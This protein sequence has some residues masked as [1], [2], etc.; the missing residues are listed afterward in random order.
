MNTIQE[1]L[2]FDDVLIE[3]RYSNIDSR[4]NIKIKS[5]LTKNISLYLPLISSPMDTITESEMAIN[6][7]TNGG[8][9]IIH[10]YN[11][12][13]QQVNMVKNVKRHLSFIIEKPYTVY[14]NETIETLL[15]K[16]K[17][18]KV[19][20]Y[21]VT[22]IDEILVGI[23]TK[24]DLNVHLVSGN[25]NNIHVS[26]IMTKDL[27]TANVDITREEA[28]KIMNL[29]K[30]EKLPVVNDDN[31]IGLISYKSLMAYELNKDKYSLDSKGQLLVGAS[32]GI[33]DDYFERAS[34]LVEAGCNILCVDVANGYNERVKN[35]IKELKQLNVDIMA[36]NVCNSEGFEFLC[37][38]GADCI[39]VGIG[40]GSICSTRLVTGVGSGQFS[41]LMKCRQIA[42]LYKVGMISDGGHLGKDGNISKAFIVGSDA[43]MLGKTLAATD[44]TPGNIIYRN[45][46]RVKCYRGMASAM[47]MVSKAEM[48][49][50]EYNSSQNP[51]G[52]DIE[53][54][55]KGPVSDIL[56]R[57]ESS[58][59]ST[60]S[61]V[62]CLNTEALREIE[63]KIVYNRQSIGV[64]SETSIR[65]KMM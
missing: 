49:N 58:I 18:T 45:N 28:L 1:S 42:R 11:T 20:S 30:I 15:N 56:Q 40:N 29:H 7:A 33:V 60:M 55:I 35:V 14:E 47:A 46:R 24:R 44:E 32:V 34:A 27:I 13:D 62:G 50:K 16:I 6:M 2:S 9:G 31:S 38:A 61:Y 36:G 43:M 48:T 8:L 53:V 41:S 10:R 12:I 25:K 51:E 19:Q 3:P 54:E 52:A 65:G 63:E 22:N 64:M 23:I 21:L 59:K 37:L 4:K 57:I 26:E 5:R 39:R 17:Q